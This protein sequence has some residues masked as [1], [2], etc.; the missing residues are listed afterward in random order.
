MNNTRFANAMHMLTVLAIHEGEW[1]CSEYI[2]ASVNVNP[3]VVRRELSVLN[4]AGFVESRK[5]KDGGSRLAKGSKEILI[6]D[7]YTAVRNVE[8]LGKKHPF[9][10]VH[11]PVGKKINVKLNELFCETDQV[12][13]NFLQHKTLDD[14]M[15]QFK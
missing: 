5:G 10:N 13:I 14:F 4:E 7:I 8:V 6:S 15:C 11:C 3:V 9:P 12:V 2:A 1:V